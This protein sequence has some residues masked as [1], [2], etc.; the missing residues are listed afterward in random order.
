MGRIVFFILGITCFK[1]PLNNL[2]ILNGGYSNLNFYLDSPSREE[3]ELFVDK[4]IELSK[5]KIREKYSRIDSDLP[6]DTFMN[7]LNWLL[8][9]KLIT[10]MEY[11]EKK[12]EYKVS[13]LIK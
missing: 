9:T 12:R 13:K 7:Q 11:D 2:L 1:A 3:V 5:H 4:L 6:E 8:N 10:E